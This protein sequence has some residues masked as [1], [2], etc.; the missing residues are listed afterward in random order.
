[1]YQ[2]SNVQHHAWHDRRQ[3]EESASA[4]PA[5]GRGRDG[6]EERDSRSG[7]KHAIS[8]LL[9]TML[10][11]I[12]V[13]WQLYAVGSDFL[14]YSMVSEVYMEKL[15]DIIPPSFS[16]CFPFLEL[17]DWRQSLL[18]VS[19]ISKKTW[20][21][22][23]ESDRNRVRERM[24]SNMSIRQIFDMTPDLKDLLKYSQVRRLE[25]FEISEDAG[26]ID[27]VKFV[28]DDLICYRLSNAD[29]V[30]GNGRKSEKEQEFK[31]SSHHLTYGSDPGILLSISLK[32]SRF[33]NMSKV[34]MFL[35]PS[36]VYPRGD[37][38]FSFN[39]ISSSGS[40]VFGSD[41]G[42]SYIG[43][44]YTKI[45]LHL[46]PPPFLTRCYDYQSHDFESA[47]HCVHT[48][49][50]DK[51]MSRMNRTSFTATF[52]QV[53]DDRM[54]SKYSVYRNPKEKQRFELMYESCKVQ[55]PGKNCFKQI[56]SPA[57]VSIRN[58]SDITFVLYAMNGPEY[59]LRFKPATS[60]TELYVQILSVCG[61]WLGI[62]C[63]DIIFNSCSVCIGCKRGIQR[64][65]N[66]CKRLLA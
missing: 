13:T 47:Y 59:I 29:A 26:M 18:N 46:L 45:S 21:R 30:I 56:F 49:L 63:L 7:W 32:K 57:L 16:I 27:V 43:L 62:S 8:L 25:S 23:K 48:C 20:L 55:C 58:S 1:M 9:T 34:M 2:Q 51:L 40:P 38:D 28:K 65:F 54:L 4:A 50:K 42:S 36:D 10:C 31:L 53:N 52:T 17:M 39:F 19:I 41:G 33:E 11:S 60:P 35:H 24:Q 22:M 5:S 37:G 12:G 3:R 6:G 44:T 15:D 14:Q 64:Q 61:A 66:K